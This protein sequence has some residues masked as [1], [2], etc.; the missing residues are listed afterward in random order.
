V[1]FVG[2][3]VPEI[4]NKLPEKALFSLTETA[5]SAMFKRYWWILLAMVP[6]AVLGCFLIA[7]IITYLTPSKFESTAVI[8]ILD[9]RLR[10]N[11]MES[12]EPRTEAFYQTEIKKITSRN[13]LIKAIESLDLSKRW[14]VDRET[15]LAILKGALKPQQIR[16][17]DLISI[18][19]IHTNREDARDIV[20]EVSRAYIDYRKELAEKPLAEMVEELH[21]MLLNQE[22]SVA[23]KRKALSLISMREDTDSLGNQNLIDAKRDL[24]LELAVLQETKLKLTN[25][26][27]EKNS[28][29]LSSVVVHDDPIISETP[30]S[31]N[32]TRSLMIGLAA[33]LF[34]SPFLALPMMW[35]LHRKNSA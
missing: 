4:L 21:K 26:E 5:T 8:E 2:F 22:D 14:G 3:A 15:A 11:G 6:V 35:I 20:A 33:G 10:V 9:H 27:I 29:N 30:V 7:A 34:L 25:Y 24:E 18:S 31:P 12:Q 19:A 32:V 13:S 23:E 16:G 1:R 17:T 28:P